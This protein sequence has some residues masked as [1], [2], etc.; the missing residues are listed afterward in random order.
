MVP[1][2]IV[3]QMIGERGFKHYVTSA[4]TGE[5]VE[6]AFQ[7]VVTDWTRNIIKQNLGLIM[8]KR[9]AEKN[10]KVNAVKEPKAKGPK[11]G[12]C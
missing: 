10:E 4:K 8:E 7:A 3:N 12:C 9:Q 2:D 11:T 5:G 1:A 6:E